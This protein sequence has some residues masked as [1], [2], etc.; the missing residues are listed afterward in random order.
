MTRSERSPALAAYPRVQISE[1]GFF[2]HHFGWRVLEQRAPRI[3]LLT[4][5]VGPARKLLFLVDGAKMAEVDAVAREHGVFRPGTVLS[6]HDFADDTGAGRVV[7]GRAL[8]AKGAAFGAGTFIFDLREDEATIFGRI[9]DRDRS[10]I[11]K[12]ERLGARTRFTRMPTADELGRFAALYAQMATERSLE[13]VSTKA[14]GHLFREGR[15]IFGAS[16]DAS[17]R[18]LTMHV[19]YTQAAHGY[20]LLGVRDPDVADAAGGLFQWEL[21]RHL[22]REG[23]RWYDFGLVPNV[24]PGN[25]LYRFKN[26]FGGH[27]LPSGHSYENAP[28]WLSRAA[29]FAGRLRH[30]FF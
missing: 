7:A 28:L 6:F 23:I 8:T 14:L 24:D 10:K 21:L 12:A 16:L 22:K 5:S 18:A 29:G 25:G 4:K 30:R 27:W 13:L 15:A 26:S 3:K 9:A 20:F 19:T 17:G 2:E 1:G 11:R